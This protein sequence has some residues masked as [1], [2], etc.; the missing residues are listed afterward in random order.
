MRKLNISQVAKISLEAL[1]HL[2]R[3]PG[4]RDFG[5]YL[6]HSAGTI[7]AKSRALSKETDVQ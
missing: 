6:N 3:M 2:V 7:D 1:Q 4:G 5:K